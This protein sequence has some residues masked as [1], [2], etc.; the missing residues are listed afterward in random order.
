MGTG[1]TALGE[2]YAPAAVSLRTARFAPAFTPAGS[3][4]S[5]AR[6]TSTTATPASSAC[7]TPTHSK[8]RVPSTT[9]SALHAG[10][11]AEGGPRI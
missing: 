3:G 11:G 6:G 10:A 7:A 5:G 4:A 1:P 8:V 2:G 9:G